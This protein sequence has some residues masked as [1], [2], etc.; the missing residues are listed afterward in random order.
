MIFVNRIKSDCQ[1]IADSLD[2]PLENIVGLAAEESE[3][4]R[5]RIARE[6]N[7]YFSMHAPA[8]LE[9]DEKPARADP[10]VKVAV[11]DTF[12]QSGKSFAQRYGQQVKGQK[13]PKEFAQA[14][15]RCRFNSGDDKTGGRHDFVGYLT[16]IISDAKARLECPVPDAKK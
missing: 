4:G 8:P 16:G 11:F 14:L 7:N 2:V 6:Y 1:T 10:K 13:D 3:W 15:V 9:T 12:L 5:G